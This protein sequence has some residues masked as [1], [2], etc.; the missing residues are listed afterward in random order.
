LTQIVDAKAK[1]SPKERPVLNTGWP[2]DLTWYKLLYDWQTIIAGVLALIAGIA[3]YRAGRQQARATRQ[4][5][6][7]QVEA[8]QLRDEREVNVLRK[9]LATELRQLIPQ[10]L[11]AHNLLKRL[12]TTATIDSP[13]TA[14]MV[15]N[16]SR[17]PPAVVYSVS[18][19]KI[20]LLAGSDAMD[21]VTIYNMIEI[22]RGGAAERIRSR[23]PDNIEP[24]TVAAVA[25]AFLK[26]CQYAAQEVFPKFKTGVALHDDVDNAFLKRV[27][28]T[29]VAWDTLLK[30]W[31][32]LGAVPLER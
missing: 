25:D 5:A 7:M 8:D 27:T 18:A 16:S 13:I 2:A 3:A 12:V 29:A 19:P 21:I 10:A 11:A 24:R 4:A 28:E 26:A 31:P 17:V 20:G 9:S 22:A 32:K 23:T 6:K 15:E 30:D 1:F 14:R